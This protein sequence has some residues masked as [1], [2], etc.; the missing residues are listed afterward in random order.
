M[1]ANECSINLTWTAPTYSGFSITGYVIE[2]LSSDGNY[3]SYDG[4]TSPDETT[5]NV[6]AQ[7][8]TDSPYNLAFG[9]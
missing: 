6:T 1:S 2:I 5:C 4:C 9:E 8:L 7:T 3:E